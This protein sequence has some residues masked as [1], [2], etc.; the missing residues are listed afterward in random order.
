MNTYFLGIVFSCNDIHI[1]FGIVLVT[2]HRHFRPMLKISWRNMGDYENSFFGLACCQRFVQPIKLS[3]R[4]GRVADWI[5]GF[6]MVIK[7]GIEDNESLRY[8]EV[9]AWIAEDI[10][11]A[12]LKLFR[13]FWP[14]KNEE[15]KCITK[16]KFIFCNAVQCDFSKEFCIDILWFDVE[17][18][19]WANRARQSGL[20]NLLQKRALGS[21]YYIVV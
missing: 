3:A 14:A 8:V 7:A 1:A 12:L 11:A 20:R 18:G 21:V 13:F 17:V 5:N 9:K 6:V 15:N 16:N 10:I 19:L 4:I 2:E